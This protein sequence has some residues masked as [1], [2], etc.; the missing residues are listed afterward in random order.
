MKNRWISQLDWGLCSY[1]VMDHISD[2]SVKKDFDVPT[3]HAPLKLTLDIPIIN[4]EILH[5]RARTFQEDQAVTQQLCEKPI[6]L[7]RI[8]L[9][10]FQ[11]NLPDPNS[12]ITFSADANV[13]CDTITDVLYKTC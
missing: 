9:Q 8:S 6:P 3:N 11:N 12:C 13:V 5:E 4:T 7:G 1:N 10:D 2:Y